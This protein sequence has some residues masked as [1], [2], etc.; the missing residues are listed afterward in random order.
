ML[1]DNLDSWSCAL[2]YEVAGRSEDNKL[3]NLYQNYHYDE[4]YDAEI[5]SEEPE[6]SFYEDWG[7]NY[8]YVW[9]KSSFSLIYTSVLNYL[10]Y[11]KV[12]KNSI[13][14]NKK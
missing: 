11:W 10:K 6:S 7:E 14:L 3:V 4:A 9:A 5:M 12:L 13:I 1:N 2:G 8:S